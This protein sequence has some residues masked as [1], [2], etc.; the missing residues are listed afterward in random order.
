MD[1]AASVPGPLKVAVLVK[2]VPRFEAMELGPGGR[3]RREGL[4]AEMNPY[5]RRAVAQATALVAGRGGAGGAMVVLTLGP[6]P[7]AEVLREAVAWAREH[8]VDA[9]GVHLCDPAFAGSDTLAT[10]R[11]LATAIRREG[12]PGGFDL[13]LA[14]LN[15]VDADTGQVGPQVAELLDLP[16]LTGVRQL[17]TDGRTLDARCELDDGWMEAQVDLPAVLSVAERLIEP[18]K[19]P[20]HRRAGVPT[21]RIL[22]IGAAE[23]GPGPWGAE[24]SPTSVGPVRVSEIGRE[25]HVFAGS[26]PGELVRRAVEALRERGALDAALDHARDAGTVPGP[27]PDPPAPG[28]DLVVVAERGR[29]GATREL[30][31]AAAVAAAGLAGRVV[32]LVPEGA[33]PEELRSWGADAAFSY[34][35]GLVAEQAAGLVAGTAGPRPPWAVL[36]P[37]TTWGREVASRAAV[38]LGA[39]L[40]GDAVELEVRASARPRLVAWKPAFGGSVLAP[41]TASSDVQIVTVRPGAL[42]HLGPR[43]AGRPGGEPGRALDIRP[44]P[45][46]A[47]ARVRV[48]AR[49]RDD[50]LDVLAL[51]TVVIGVGTGVA[52]GEYAALEPLR[53]RLGAELGATRKVTDRGW[54]PRARQIGITGRSVA[55]RLYVAVGLAG[56]FNHMA[57]VRAAHTVLAFNTDPAAPVFDHADVGVVGDW[58][59]C[60]PLLVSEL[61]GGADPARSGR[62]P[63]LR[64]ECHDKEPR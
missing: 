3:L 8:G 54:L 35:A 1:A 6:E 50:D 20:A 27:S 40:T 25:R 36:A 33:D 21:D 13:V 51:A 23:L 47:A 58:H 48:T 57:G 53:S 42:P 30:L 12:G 5:C 2:Q 17:S 26:P 41:V 55:P 28:L 60:I 22:R 43:P 37:G 49:E 34:P 63:A 19:V 15:S 59:A 9:R 18:A 44:A 38:R 64:W 4:E 16:F 10:S 46:A 29:A 7:A 14:G 31:G 56:K 39:G 61:E 52:P 32:A 11:A 62:E 24:G 45:P